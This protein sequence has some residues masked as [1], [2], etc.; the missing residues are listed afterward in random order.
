[1]PGKPAI[2]LTYIFGARLAIR[3]ITRGDNGAY[4]NFLEVRQIYLMFKTCT[5]F[6]R[7]KIGKSEKHKL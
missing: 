7:K 5:P 4:H 2:L 6:G 3:G 1:M